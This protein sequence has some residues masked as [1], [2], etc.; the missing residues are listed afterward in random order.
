MK[1]KIYLFLHYLLIIFVVM[2]S[3]SVRAQQ[4]F[5]IRPLLNSYVETKLRHEDITQSLTR[6]NTL[7][8]QMN[9]KQQQAFRD[10]I[11]SIILNT[12]S[13]EKVEEGVA[14]I[15]VY[16]F[17]STPEDPRM[18]PLYFF[19]GEYA[20]KELRDTIALKECI[21][22]L[23]VC[24]VNSQ[25]DA[26]SYLDSLNM[27][28]ADI[29]NFVPIRKSID[30]I[31]VATSSRDIWEKYRLTFPCMALSIWE[32]GE[33]IRLTGGATAFKAWQPMYGSYFPTLESLYP[34]DVVELEGGRLYMCWSNEKLKTVDKVTMGIVSTGVGEMVGT[35]RSQIMEEAGSS[36]GNQLAG[37]LAGG[38]LSFGTDLLLDAIFSPK[39]KIA[40]LECELE[41]IND[42][43]LRAEITF[44][45]ITV[46]QDGKPN[47]KEE[48]KSFSLIKCNPKWEA[49]FVNGYS[50]FF[51][52]PHLTN[53][54]IKSKKK[55][56]TP[57]GSYLSYNFF[58]GKNSFKSA[59]P[60]NAPYN[61]FN[62]LAMSKI[63]SFN[64]QQMLRAGLKIPDTEIHQRFKNTISVLGIEGETKNNGVYIS[65]VNKATF[66]YFSNLK[67]GDI[68]HSID[69][70]QMK[71]MDDISDYIQSLP[72][73]S[74]VTIKLK[75]GKKILE[76]KV[77]TSMKFVE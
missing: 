59:I 24:N 28:L 57:M 63:I 43:E 41:K 31:W 69:G 4:V 25:P 39:K 32:K 67:K 47:P 64:E 10:S 26:Q 34:Q 76:T 56:Q 44:Q 9:T 13:C 2:S 71:T 48:K 42:Y 27:Y 53:K 70:F 62:T 12:Q 35:M 74:T 5:P 54:E 22:D 51:I 1:K 75:R 17:F 60:K 40:I 65:K 19:L 68:I 49:F 20:A 15:D 11:Y 45:N 18:P 55:E 38:M 66:A 73:F 61:L 50:Y 33:K 36:F 6:L 37:N 77:E 14:L 52:G 23:L 3:L 7:F 21:N 46:N 16:K 30:G 8:K 29:R 58:D 72:P